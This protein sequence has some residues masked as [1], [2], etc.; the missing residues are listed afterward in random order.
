MLDYLDSKK[1]KSALPHRQT[2]DMIDWNHIASH[3][4]WLTFEEMIEFSNKED[5]VSDADE[6]KE[7]ND[8][9]IKRNLY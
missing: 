2:N 6:R 5:L 9:F 1:L 8:F 4:G 7:I 3:I